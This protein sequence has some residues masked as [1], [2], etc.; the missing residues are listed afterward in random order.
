[1]C[2]SAVPAASAASLGGA[3]VRP[4]RRT[5]MKATCCFSAVPWPTMADLTWAGV[6]GWTETSALPRVAR[7][8]PRLSARMR[9]DFGFRPLKPDSTAAQSGASSVTT[10]AN[11]RPRSASRAAWSVPLAEWSQKTRAGSGCR[12]PRS[13]P[14]RWLGFPDQL[15]RRAPLLHPAES[16][17][18]GP[19]AD[20]IRR[21]PVHCR[22][23]RSWPR[24][25]ERRPDRRRPP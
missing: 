12:S 5:T 3:S 22:R 4:R 16:D 2:V 8:T 13:A 9:P 7:S 19:D 1:M 6:Y 24:R 14:S 21:C 18:R 17:R 15:L 23:Y 10:R 20:V 25:S 11:R